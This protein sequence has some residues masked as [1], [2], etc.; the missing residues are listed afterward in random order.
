ML[1]CSA[2]FSDTTRLVVALRRRL[3]TLSNRALFPV[4][5]RPT[6]KLK[7]VVSVN[8]LKSAVSTN[9]SSSIVRSASARGAPRMFP[10]KVRERFGERSADDRDVVVGPRVGLGFNLERIC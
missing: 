6:T 10:T 4:P 2:G 8:A 7:V 3:G 5:R 1:S 9:A